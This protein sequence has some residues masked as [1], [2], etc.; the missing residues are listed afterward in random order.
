MFFACRPLKI[1]GR[2]V[3]AGDVIDGPVKKSLLKSGRVR[4]VEAIAGSPQPAPV[5]VVPSA[6]VPA[7]VVEAPKPEPM[8]EPEPELRT[9]G[10]RKK[11]R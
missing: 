2:L 1:N 9:F 3:V 10:R 8:P 7:P 4:E 5:A 11:G 6:P